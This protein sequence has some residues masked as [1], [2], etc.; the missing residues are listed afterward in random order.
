[1]LNRFIF[2]FAYTAS[3]LGRKA[4]CCALVVAAMTLFVPQAHAR[5]ASIVIEA[6]TGR[7][8]HAVNADTRKY[9]AS[10]TKMM[11]LYM[12]FD[13]LDKGKLK[14]GQRLQVS[15]RATQMP[16]SK[17]GLKRGKSIT[18]KNAVLAL[19]TKSA[20]DVA[21]VI[22]EALGGTESQFARQMTDRARTLGMTRTTFRNAS[23]LPNSR[24]KSTARDMSILAS[25]LLRQFPEYYHYFSTTRFSY[26]GRVY[27]NHNRLL[28]SYEGMDGIK[29]GYIRA[30]GFNLVASAKRNG[31]RL[32]G[33]VFGGKSS[34]SRDRHMAKLLNRSFG[35]LAIAEGIQGEP[36]AP[37]RNPF[38]ALQVAKAPNKVDPA[39]HID[40]DGDLI[41]TKDTVL[42]TAIQTAAASA[43]SN[44]PAQFTTIDLPSSGFTVVGSDAAVESV[45]LETFQ[46]ARADAVT[47]A[48]AAPTVSAQPLPID[49]TGG[50]WTIQVGAFREF[51][52]AQSVATETAQRLP[53]LLDESKA[54][55]Q[56]VSIDDS[57]M[58]RAQLT[59]LSESSAREAC[60]RLQ[61]VD[62]G[63]LVLSP[64]NYSG[65][66]ASEG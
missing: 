8:I 15:K 5:Y 48:K 65:T 27:G 50:A 9:P 34:R 22:A 19:V 63:C 40:E 24:Q 18:V 47:I 61:E 35:E 31:R 16:P 21:V 29:T 51:G 13:A 14:L 39:A 25:A 52:P 30:S 36:P 45:A 64:R 23:G 17:L 49:T 4:L 43:A 37:G 62:R 20:N 59:G 32:I 33:V 46:V 11:T 57:P 55:I 38:H 42:P 58:Y 7:V 10:L 41:L 6:G 3:G 26:R 12:V 56:Q 28:K 44:E 60:R 54:L 66:P 1:M 53:G 2:S